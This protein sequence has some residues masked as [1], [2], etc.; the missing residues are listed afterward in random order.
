MV[1]VKKT[2]FLCRPGGKNNKIDDSR[3][4]SERKK[5]KDLQSMT[6]TRSYW[7]IAL[8]AIETSHDSRLKD[9]TSY[10]FKFGVN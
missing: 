5:S 1:W 9:F 6:S 2:H 3:D 8:Y 7:N 4:S 10:K